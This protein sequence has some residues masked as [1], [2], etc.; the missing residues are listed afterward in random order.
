MRANLSKRDRS[1]K[2]VSQVAP[3][4][5]LFEPNADARNVRSLPQALPAPSPAPRYARVARP[6]EL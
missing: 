1:L 6:H 3:F 5:A 4:V 2:H